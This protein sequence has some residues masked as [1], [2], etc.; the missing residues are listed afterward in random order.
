ME[1]I[2]LFKEKQQIIPNSSFNW[3]ERPEMQI[4]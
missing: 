1:L 4:T 3:S 2:A